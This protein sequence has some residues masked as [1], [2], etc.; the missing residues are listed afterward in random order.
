VVCS[1]DCGLPEQEA[2]RTVRAGHLAEFTEALARAA[3]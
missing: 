2:L 1:E 3:A